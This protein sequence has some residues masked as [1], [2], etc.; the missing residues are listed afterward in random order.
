[1]S[2]D[3]I[4]DET[5]VISVSEMALAIGL[6]RARL[7]QL[8]DAGKLPGP[9]YDIR[10]RRPHYPNELQEICLRVKRTGIATDGAP[11]AFY[12]RRQKPVVK[13]QTPSVTQKIESHDSDTHN[14]EDLVE[15]LL[16]MGVQTDD[17]SVRSAIKVLAPP[18]NVDEGVL[19]RDLFRHLRKKGK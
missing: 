9:V 4:S 16:E 10:T 11:L 12:R 14:C 19:L 5:S 15:A 17:M 18:D 3:H 8:I 2:E 13:P 6:S 7:Y 1:M